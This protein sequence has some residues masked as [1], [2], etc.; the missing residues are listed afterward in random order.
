MYCRCVPETSMLNVPL[1]GHVA[2]PHPEGPA[3][4]DDV[5]VDESITVEPPSATLVRP[6]EPLAPLEDPPPD[7]APE[8]L[9]P[10][11]SSL[12]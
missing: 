6:E 5:A 7:D 3:S 10:L 8:G 1:A 2:A 11:S 12:I 9:P 4:D